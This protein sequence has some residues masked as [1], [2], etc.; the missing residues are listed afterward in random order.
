MLILGIILFL[1]GLSLTLRKRRIFIG[2][3]SIIAGVVFLLAGASQIPKESEPS[4]TSTPTSTATFSKQGP[5][6]LLT[7]Q[8]ATYDHY[9]WFEVIGV[10]ENVG[11]EPAF[12]PTIVLDIWDR[13]GKTLLAQDLTWPAGQYLSKMA[14]GVSA[15]FHHFTR[16]P[17]EPRSIK[18]EIYVKDY[19]YDVKYPK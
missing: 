13:S 18:Y 16:I 4:Y 9:G 2:L 3:L 8:K 15:T 11:D 6:I 5:K 10:A 12:S 7:I 17:G 14:P 19:P 1:V